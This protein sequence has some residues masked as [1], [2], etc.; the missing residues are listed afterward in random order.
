MYKCQ[1]VG[2]EFTLIQLLKQPVEKRNSRANQ[3]VVADLP[4]VG[5]IAEFVTGITLHK[6]DKIVE[7]KVVRDPFVPHQQLYPINEVIDIV[8]RV[9]TPR[10]SGRVEQRT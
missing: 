3:V 9:R 7:N 1:C 2:A 8:L 10:A 6:V 4:R 5:K